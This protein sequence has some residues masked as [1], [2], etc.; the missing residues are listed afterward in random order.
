MVQRYPALQEVTRSRIGIPASANANVAALMQADLVP[1]EK[2]QLERVNSI[3]IH[4]I[5]MDPIV[6]C[7]KREFLYNMSK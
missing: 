4:R 1:K 7:M 5:S 3:S 2:K 6:M